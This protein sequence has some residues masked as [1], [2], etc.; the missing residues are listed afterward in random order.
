M[1]ENA[2]SKTSAHSSQA[3]GAASRVDRLNAPINEPCVRLTRSS[4][5]SNE[6]GASRNL[7]EET[8]GIMEAQSERLYNETKQLL[9]RLKPLTEHLTGK[10]L[11]KGEMSL[12]EALFE[13][14]SF[15]AACYEF[16]NRAGLAARV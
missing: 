4:R 15:E 13:I 5:S 1:L 2:I 9:S 3:R 12:Q 10:L 16:S 14:R 6:G 11:D 7:D 8:R